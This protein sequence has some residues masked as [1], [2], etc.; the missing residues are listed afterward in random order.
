MRH[1]KFNTRKER[2]HDLDRLAFLE[3]LHRGGR[4]PAGDAPR[5]A[6]SSAPAPPPTG[7]R[8]SRFRLVGDLLLALSL[9]ALLWGLA[10]I[11]LEITRIVNG[12]L[13]LF[14]GGKL[15]LIWLLA[16][17][18]AYGVLKA[19]GEAFFLGSDIAE[20]CNAGVECTIHR[21]RHGTTEAGPESGNKA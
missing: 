18:T 20:L 11:G 9:L 14:E 7:A 5:P 2:K 12:T 4:S 6:G 19:A 1:K 21:L 13:T 8:Y 17:T 3:D 10:G 15:I 16:T